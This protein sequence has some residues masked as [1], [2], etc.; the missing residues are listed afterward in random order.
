MYRSFK[1]VWREAYTK[2]TPSHSSAGET[3]ES[4][5]GTES[6][7]ESTG[8]S[9][10]SAPVAAFPFATYA[11]AKAGSAAFV[12]ARERF[13]AHPLFRLWERNEPEYERFT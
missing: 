10:E 3:T 12:D 1:D 13:Y 5:N 8:L 4:C 2:G 11:D 9:E 6:A 7:G